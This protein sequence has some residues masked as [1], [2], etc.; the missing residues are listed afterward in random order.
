MKYLTALSLV[1]L[2]ACS[3]APQIVPDNT[4]ES[5]ILKKINHEISTGASFQTGWQWILW[6]LPLLFLVVTWGWRQWIRNCQESEDR[7]AEVAKEQESLKKPKT[8]EN[9]QLPNG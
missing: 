8:E 4:S 6:Y 3:T 9:T 2:T 1:L 5:V 7:L